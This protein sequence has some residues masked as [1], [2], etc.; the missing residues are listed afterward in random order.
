MPS[1]LV[2]TKLHVPQA[3]HSVV[4]RLRLA[5]RLGGS[6]RP[7]LTLVSGPAGFGKTT[8]LASWAGAA[9][10]R[11]V[12]WVSLEETE[13]QPGSFWTYV[14]TALDTAVPGTGVGVLPLLQAP[15]PPME[16]VLATLLNELG[17]LPDGV[18]LVLDDYHLVDG[19]QLADDVAFLLEH[20]PPDV[21]V[22]ISTRA[23]PALPLARLRAR[24]ELVEIRAADLRFTLDEVSTYLNDVVGLDLD[25]AEIAALEGRTEG[26]IAALQLAALSLQG[27]ADVAGFIAGFA[28]DD[29]YV[30]DYL[31]EE[32]LGRQPEAVRSFLLDTSILD[33]LSGPL[34]D[35]VT[36]R[37]DG[38]AVVESLERSN[39]FVI[40]LDDNRRWYRYH[41]LFADVLRAHLLEERPDD[42]AALHRRAAKWYA[43]AGEPVPAVRHALDAG[44]VEQA[45]DVIEGSAIGLLRQRQEATVR[46]WLDDI[47]Y[48]A[49]RR[50]PVL[51]V[52]FI[53][54]LMSR[55]DFETVGVRLDDLERLL[56]DPPANM[57]VLDE[58]ELARVPGAMETYRAALALVAGD[59]AG[60][61]AHADLAMAR[62]APGDDLTVA[63]AAALAGLAAWGGGDLEAAHRGYAVAVR[64]LERAGNISDVLGCSIALSDLRLT[65]GRLGDALRTYEDALRLAAAHE[66]DEPLRGTADMVVGL[67]QVVFER[68]DLGATAAH[69]LRVDTLG[70]RLGLPQL[71]YRW[72]VARAR[73][74]EAEGDLAGAVALLEEAERVYVGDYSPNVRPVAAQ[75]ARMLLAQGRIDEA[76]DWVRARHLA[77]DDELSYVREYEHLTLARILMGRPDASGAALR[78]ARGL[79]DRLG[80]AAEGGGRFGTLIE[81]L[82][83][84]ALAH[85][86]EHGRSDVLGALAPLVQALRLAEP[87]GYVWVFVSEG[88]PLAALLEAVVR[89]HP[90]WS[91]PRRLVAGVGRA[92]IGSVGQSP[93]DQLSERELDVLRLLAT[94]LDGPEISRRL[95]ISLNTL[96]T[97]TRNIYAKLGVNSRRTAV[98][99]A[100]ELGLL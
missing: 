50:R 39:L 73:L 11:P 64:G 2:S 99:K 16:S 52:A 53:G 55:N 4:P 31:V 79:L 32:V 75:R 48:D 70:E 57:V 35:A 61:V 65:Q 44:D 22:V 84:Q 100:R 62:A 80:V 1:P 5:D 10:G 45:A 89:R 26:W 60:T 29:R 96:R 49:V 20:L 24:G 37:S 19:P 91:Y 94:D 43:A 18:D 86:A 42:V 82:T 71:P 3:R 12:A 6:A 28:G 15:H 33:R 72:R 30:V 92:P 67:S 13:Q 59:P 27:R 97:H 56:A 51:A 41:H 77:P 68:G 87:E 47:P 46:G 36:N 93:L 8:L 38:K 7:R 74:R 34:C 23:D 85:H 17:A 58:A 95:Y 9:A 88:A 14:V 69:L 76:L 40:A 83:L 25:T 66:V 78:A 21:Q 98:T 63:A 81:I 90:S 54:A